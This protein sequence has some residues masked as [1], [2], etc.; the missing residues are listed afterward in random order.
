ME[1]EGAIERLK[2]IMHMDFQAMSSSER[3]I[4]TCEI[5]EIGRRLESMHTDDCALEEVLDALEEKL[6][7][8]QDLEN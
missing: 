8:K 2:E 5:S 3:I 1:I 7:L 6:A 4:L